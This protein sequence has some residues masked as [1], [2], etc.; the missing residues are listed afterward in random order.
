[1]SLPAT[2]QPIENYGVI[3]DMRTTA[4]VGTDGS[5]DWLCFPYFDSPSVFAAIHDAD[6]GGRFR[7]APAVE[8]YRTKQLYWP[9]SRVL[10][11]RFLAD[12]GV[13]QIVDYM[14]VGDWGS[15]PLR[16]CLIRHVRCI[17]GSMTLRM[18]CGP[19]FDFVRAEHR[20]DVTEGGVWFRSA[21]LDLA[22]GSDVPVRVEGGAA[23][24]DFALGEREQ[25]SFVL[26]E[27]EEDRAV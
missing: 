3:G 15:R 10:V 19:A 7:I 2:Y 22:L 21:L 26:G 1:M 6:K 4:L 14:P 27:A 17:R 18:H 8:N 24:A 13:A 25:V 5:I 23:I 12:S 20:V 16:R 9:D 11:T